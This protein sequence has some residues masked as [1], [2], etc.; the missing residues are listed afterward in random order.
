MVSLREMNRPVLLIAAAALGSYLLVGAVG[1]PAAIFGTATVLLLA[2]MA[3]GL[4]ERI[5]ARRWLRTRL[6]LLADA[7]R[8]GRGAR[9]RRGQ[10]GVG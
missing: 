4:R 7:R 3:V 5:I 10:Q 8:R 9:P 2:V 6:R 1:L